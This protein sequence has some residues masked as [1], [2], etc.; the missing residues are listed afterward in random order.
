MTRAL[1]ILAL[2]SL[3]AAPS[4][5]Q[6]PPR[7]EG[8]A[9]GSCGQSGALVLERVQAQRRSDERWEILVHIRN[10]TARTILFTMSL[11]AAGGELA[12]T[13]NQPYRVEG[14]GVLV[15]PAGPS[16]RTVPTA[17]VLAGLTLNCPM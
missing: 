4:P 12:R 1:L 8:R 13:A 9:R 2:L 14:G 5:A 7:P 3:G 11:R 10:T 16:A 6:E 17:E 15:V